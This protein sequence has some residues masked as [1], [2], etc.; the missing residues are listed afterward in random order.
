M[1]Y[2]MDYDM[3]HGAELDQ[4]EVPIACHGESIE[5]TG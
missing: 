4:R 3:G 5:R 2:D 1:D